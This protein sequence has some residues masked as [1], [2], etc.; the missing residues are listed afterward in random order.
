LCNLRVR[1][2]NP[3]TTVINW[4]RVDTVAKHWLD[5]ETVQLTVCSQIVAV[6]DIYVVTG[7]EILAMP[8]TTDC[9]KLAGLQLE[10]LVGV[11]G[12]QA[13]FTEAGALMQGPELNMGLQELL[14][15]AA[16]SDT[17]RVVC[18]SAHAMKTLVQIIQA[19]PEM[20]SE[21]WLHQSRALNEQLK[22][23]DYLE[24]TSPQPCMIISPVHSD[25]PLHWTLLVLHRKQGDMTFQVRWYDSLPNS[26]NTA[27][28]SAQLH[29]D[30]IVSCLR[31][32]PVKTCVL[33]ASETCRKQTDGHSCGPFSL[34]FAEQ[35]IRQFRGEGLKIVEAKPREIVDNL[36]KIVKAV[37]G[38]QVKKKPAPVPAAKAPP[39][40][41]PPPLPPPVLPAGDPA[42]LDLDVSGCS[43]CIYCK[44]GCLQCNP[45]KAT[46][47]IARRDSKSV[48]SC[49]VD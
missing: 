40:L 14:F 3:R 20:S 12:G 23:A 18:L 33:P 5:L 45:G 29:L 24:N 16:P 28:Q 43:K 47:A 19:D 7:R 8:T 17:S 13:E 9:R 4:N 44:K 46:V 11:S 36:N 1:L 49:D 41:P 27:K 34:I 2:I 42:P 31:P 32:H 35:E 26:P 30:A 38:F 6:S 10:A 21:D 15:R 39:P 25:G 37:K 22:T 48:V